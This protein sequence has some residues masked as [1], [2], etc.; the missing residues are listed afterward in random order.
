MLVFMLGAIF[1]TLFQPFNAIKSFAQTGCQTFPETGK[2]V[3]GRFLEYW[4]TNGGLAQQG[5][6]ISGP[7]TEVSD[8]NGKPYIVQYFERSVFEL[9]P[10]NQPPNDILLS[11][12]GT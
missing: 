11:Q 12:L 3:C 2:T 1:A 6:P 10:E 7:F 9:H 4:Q 5:F 8:L